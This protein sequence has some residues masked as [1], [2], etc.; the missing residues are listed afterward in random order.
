MQNF[1]SRRSREVST[2]SKSEQ[3]VKEKSHFRKAGRGRLGIYLHSNA[4]RLVEK[5]KELAFN[6]NHRMIRYALYWTW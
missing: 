2:C 3:H 6:V 5:I 4:R 1:C